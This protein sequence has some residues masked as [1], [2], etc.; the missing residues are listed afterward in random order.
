M[1]SGDKKRAGGCF[2]K[3][4]K[5]N[6]SSLKIN[7]FWFLNNFVLDNNREFFYIFA[8]AVNKSGINK[9]HVF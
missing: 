2:F 5:L 8:L 3:L 7:V 1:K 4:S 6:F 9:S